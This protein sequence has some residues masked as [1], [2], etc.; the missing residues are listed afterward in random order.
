MRIIIAGIVGGIVMFLWGGLW[1]EQLPFGFT[2]LRS[3]PNQEAVVSSMKTNLPE[4]GMY[5]FPG[6]GLPDDAPFAQKKASMQK[7]E[8]NP[9]VGPQGVLV[10]S[11]VTRP[12]SAKQL[13]TECLTD[14]LQALLAVFLL[15]QARL[16]RYSSRVGFVIVAGLLASVTTNIAFWNWYGFPGSFIVANVAYLVVGYLLVGLI[17]AAIVKTSAPKAAAAAA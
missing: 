4:A 11:P 14:I 7:L 15:V 3:I 5:I 17:G 12:L 10:Y 16:R 6:F 1:H 13:V 8:Q 9:P 2:G